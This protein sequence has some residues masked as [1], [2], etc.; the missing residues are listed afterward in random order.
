MAFSFSWRRGW[1][2]EVIVLKF[3]DNTFWYA[4]CVKTIFLLFLSEIKSLRM[5]Q[6]STSWRTK[7]T[8]GLSSPL[9]LLLFVWRHQPFRVV[10]QSW[11]IPLAVVVIMIGAKEGSCTYGADGVDR[12]VNKNS[13]FNIRAM[14][15]GFLFLVSSNRN[16]FSF[17]HWSFIYFIYLL[18]SPWQKKII[19]SS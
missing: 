7:C 11:T 9:C 15:D 2:E 10:C 13:D 19:S 3:F 12:G 1:R 6:D 8:I 5:L 18:L 4:Y 17:K 16:L 14:R